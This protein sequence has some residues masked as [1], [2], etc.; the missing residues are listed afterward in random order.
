MKIIS[1]SLDLSKIDKSRI[2]EKD[3]DGKPYTNGAKYYDIQIFLNSEPDQYGNHAS[4]AENMT[5]EEREA[6]RKKVYLGNGK[7]VFSNSPAPKEEHK[8]PDLPTGS[9]PDD[10]PF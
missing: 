4:I 9:E 6:G 8:Q 5:K 3:K 7:I 2:R 1:A 10:L